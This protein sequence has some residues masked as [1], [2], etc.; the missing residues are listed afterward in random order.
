MRKE[1][2]DEKELSEYPSAPDPEKG[3]KGQ[4]GIV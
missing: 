1:N 3:A 2:W 4:R